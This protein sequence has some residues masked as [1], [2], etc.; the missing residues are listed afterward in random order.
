MFK[1]LLN[2][3]SDDKRFFIIVF[4][5]LIII[6][7]LGF[8]SPI[9]VNNTKTNWEQNLN[10]KISDIQT[11][12]TDLFQKKQKLLVGKSNVLSNGL[13]T[14]YGSQDSLTSRNLYKIL[15]CDFYTGYNVG[16][17]DDSLKLVS[18]TDNYNISDF[19]ENFKSIKFGQSFF[20]NYNLFTYLA[21]TDS[22]KIGGHSYYIFFLELI[23][24]HFTLDNKYI[25][26]INLT[27]N[28]SNKFQ[29]EFSVNYF[30]GGANQPDTKKYSFDL[31]NNK[32]TKIGSASF[33]KPMLNSTLNNFEDIIDLLQSLLIAL[34][35]IVIG[36]GFKRDFSEIKY[37]SI[38]LAV[39][40]VYFILLRIIFFET[41]FPVSVMSGSIVN[42]NYFSSMF[43][44]G[45]VKSPIELFISSAFVLILAVKI[46]HY[47]IK[48]ISENKV[49]KIQ[50]PYSYAAALVST[51]GFLFL[52]RAFAAT[53]KSVIFDSTLRYFKDPDLIPDSASLLMNLN[54]FIV[55]FVITI[56][57]L[58]FLIVTI[59]LF[60]TSEQLPRKYFFY[61]VLAL[62]V[63][64][65]F[66]VLIQPNP[67]IN[68]YM[69]VFIVLAISALLY[70]VY[71][72]KSVSIYNYVY[73]AIAG[74]IISITFLN[75]FNSDLEKESLKT[76]ALEL[77]RPN[78]N[79]LRFYIDKT[80]NEAVSNTLVN[81]M[82]LENKENMNSAAF[83][84]WC[85]SPLQKESA[86]Y[87]VFVL[88]K[89]KKIKGYFSNSLKSKVSLDPIVYSY[90]NGKSQIFESS[91]PEGKKMISGIITIN[92]EDQPVGYVSITVIYSGNKIRSEFTPD[93]LISSKNIFNDVLNSNE[94]NIFTYENKKLT[95]SY[96]SLYLSKNQTE[97]LLSANF[98]DLN[99]CW[100]RLQVTGESYLFYVLKN[101][102][103][104]K[105]K[106]TVAALKEKQIS[107]NMYNF[108]KLFIIHFMFILVLII[109]IASFQIKKP[110]GFRLSFRTQLLVAFLFMSL[111]PILSLAVYNRHVVYEK[112]RQGILNELKER[113]EIVENGIKIYMD[114]GE[115]SLLTDVYKR[116]ANELKINYSIF[117]NENE[118]FTSVGS[119]SSIGILPRVIN[120][121]I[122]NR[123]MNSGFREY[124]NQEFIDNYSYISF[125]KKIILRDE[126]YII[127]INSAVNR[128]NIS[129]SSLDIDIFLFGVYSFAAL[130]IVIIGTILA[131]KISSPIRRLTKATS[132]IAHGDFNLQIA[133]E[134]KGEI[135]DL[136]NGFNLMT[137]ELNKRQAE[138]ADLERE[139]A[140]KE[141]ARQV[142]HE[143][144]NPL[145]PMKLA[146]QQLIIASKDNHPS[147]N[148]IFEKVTAT[149][150]N[151]IDNLNT[152]ASEFSNFARM[153]NYNMESVD[154]IPVV[155]DTINLF[156]DE[157][158]D[159]RLV[160]ELIT[161]PIDGDN[162]QIRRI[163]INLI[164][165]SIQAG[166]TKLIVTVFED[167][168]KYF[169]SVNDNGSGIPENVRSKIFDLNFTT[170]EMG[171]GLGLKLAQKFIESIGGKI[172][173]K[174]SSLKGSEF[175]IQLNKKAK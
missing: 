76:I 119:L 126:E 103:G 161:A 35:G 45:L 118:Y 123:L 141:M 65:S 110:Y 14:L 162:S 88:D 133:N 165:N 122:N 129:I 128:I 13:V 31:L 100:V 169:I 107:L 113:A 70:H 16:I 29:T 106:V 57:L 152:I 167:A 48:Y 33:S 139:T 18:W 32:N 117:K 116:A 93:F 41:G 147:F 87:F 78:E 3:F 163:I 42:P 137:R 79:M 38:K 140:W 23:E 60:Y 71:Y 28:L 132:S 144:K 102:F 30:A 174:T 59:R 51:A 36:F 26:K 2:R 62:I 9:V 84:I 157:K 98:S 61:G 130:I 22:I 50:K 39:L 158:I 111:I 54:T 4:F 155:K 149:V 43:G 6:M 95:D 104:P 92:R 154:L 52:V 145:T 115:D 80:L 68:F 82:Y 172:Y 138:L 127:N 58:L 40:A 37:K 170:K 148:A 7:I 49:L 69:A 136:I 112:S 175:V 17:Y 10:S 146:V 120:A 173:L 97:Q 150:L 27:E 124:S 134:E 143:I 24:K 108:F 53:I 159:I 135:K 74:S 44:Y 142:A 19:A 153:P 81:A 160:S 90:D 151:Q 114:R 75:Y 99:E 25:K 94:L 83:S 164:R 47:Y 5:I 63:L 86:D 168:E 15:S 166:S 96:G 101:P 125:Y 1:N 46:Y 20:Y 12:A 11:S 105:E 72:I 34:A 55:G 89:N 131:N 171:M 56:F 8:V 67:L 64:S 73:I 21:K 109:T 66:F 121:K 91:A 156:L 77:N 85:K